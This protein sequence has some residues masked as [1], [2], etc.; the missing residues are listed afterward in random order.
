MNYIAEMKAFYDYMIENPISA[1]G[2][3]LWHR[4]MAYANQFGW[5]R[6]FSITNTRLLLDL[7]ISKSALDRERN[8]LVQKGL[9]TY[10]KGTGN[11]CGLYSMVS[12]ASQNLINFGTQT[13]HKPDT[14]WDTNR[15]QSDTQTEPLN[16]PNDTKQNK[17]EKGTLTSTPKEKFVEPSVEEVRAY[18]MERKNGVDAQR[19]VDFYAATGWYRGKN[20]IKD[21][22][23]AVRTWEQREKEREGTERT[24]CSQEDIFAIY[25]RL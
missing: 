24:T 8:L 2:Q 17:K 14:V 22:K 16:K 10:K 5:K 19:F 4:L 3:A 7:S 1:N 9:I 20:K 23:A 13:G 18:C 21:W 6:E 25:G 15:T 11:Q 12:I